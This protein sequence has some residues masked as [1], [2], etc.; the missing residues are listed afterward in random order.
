MHQP[1]QSRLGIMHIEPHYFYYIKKALTFPHSIRPF[2]SAMSDSIDFDKSRPVDSIRFDFNPLERSETYS[3]CPSA[4]PGYVLAFAIPP[5]SVEQ[6][7]FSQ[8]FCTTT[9]KQTNEQKK[10]VRNPKES[11]F[12]PLHFVSSSLEMRL[13]SAAFNRRTF[14]R[15]RILIRFTL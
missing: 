1:T 7:R 11:E 2:Q 12:W 4:Q 14:F 13:K 9:N 6:T 10:T 15:D 8:I 5:F 3:G